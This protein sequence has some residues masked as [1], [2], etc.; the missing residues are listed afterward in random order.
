M[1]AKR[2][3]EIL[4]IISSCPVETQEQLLEA[5]KRVE[6]I[7]RKSVDSTT[8]INTVTEEQVAGVD[9][10]VRAMQGVQDSMEQ[11][12]STLHQAI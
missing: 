3:G 11:L 7:S 6:D 9:N 2:Q 4:S 8:E 12:S 5:M 10:I 1:K